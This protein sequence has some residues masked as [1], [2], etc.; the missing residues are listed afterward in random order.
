MFLLIPIRIIAAAF[1]AFGFFA[2]LD[3]ATVSI[4]A[5]WSDSEQQFVMSYPTK[6]RTA[7]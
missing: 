7:I 6:E 2:V 1:M 4:P 3:N 5:I